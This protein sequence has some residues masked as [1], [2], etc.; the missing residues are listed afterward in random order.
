MIYSID[1]SFERDA[2][3]APHHMLAALAEALTSI[4]TAQ[5]VRHIPG[6]KKLKGY[7]NCYRIKIEDYTG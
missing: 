1:K 2:K 5:A 6:I 3:K 7:K 4:R